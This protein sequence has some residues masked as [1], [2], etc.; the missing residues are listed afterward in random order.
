MENE[1]KRLPDSELEIM[2]AIW[3]IGVPATSSDVIKNLHNEKKWKLT[4]VLTFLTRLVNKGFLKCEK[5]YGTNVYTAIIDEKDYLHREN[6][7]FLQRFY[8]N[9]LKAFVSTL[10]EN[11][12][13]SSHELKELKEFIEKANK[14]EI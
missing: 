14:D 11:N 13:I 4:S 10:V 7:S 9:S 1:I 3:E 6:Q 8:G 12:S 2:M 5:Q